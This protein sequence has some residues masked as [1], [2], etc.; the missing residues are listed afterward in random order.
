[1]AKWTH[2]W[3][4]TY[5]IQYVCPDCAVAS[6]EDCEIKPKAG[7]TRECIKCG[8]EILLGK[9]KPTPPADSD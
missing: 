2:L 3:R 9:S 8:R 5:T 1:M 4:L 6:V 7:D